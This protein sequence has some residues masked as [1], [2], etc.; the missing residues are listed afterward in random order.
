MTLRTPGAAQEQRHKTE[1]DAADA[2]DIGDFVERRNA[3]QRNE[4]HEQRRE[5]RPKYIGHGAVH[6]AF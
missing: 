1:Q 4:Y 3:I 5:Q 6:P 2:H